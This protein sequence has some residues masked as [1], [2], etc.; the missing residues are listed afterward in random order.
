MCSMSL[1]VPV[2]IA[3][4]IWAARATLEDSALIATVPP[5][6]CRKRR[7]SRESLFVMPLM[8][9]DIYERLVTSRPLAHESL[10]CTPPGGI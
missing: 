3:G 4:A 6:I 5:A 8:A 7:R 2:R 9:A 10:A 1:M